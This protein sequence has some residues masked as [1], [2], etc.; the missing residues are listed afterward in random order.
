MGHQR[1]REEHFKDK[2]LDSTCKTLG[3]QQ[4][5]K[6]RFMQRLKDTDLVEVRGPI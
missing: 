5:Y 2:A 4:G 6:V 1:L 3:C